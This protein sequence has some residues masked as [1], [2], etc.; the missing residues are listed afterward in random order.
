MPCRSPGAGRPSST[1]S[2]QDSPA[3]S[4]RSIRRPRSSTIRPCGT[5]SPHEPGPDVA[6][7]VVSQRART[8]AAAPAQAAVPNQELSPSGT[9]GPSLEERPRDRDRASSGDAEVRLD[10]LLRSFMR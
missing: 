8:A 3:T 6:A 9:P 10:R 2:G 1:S 5:S 4:V 7:A